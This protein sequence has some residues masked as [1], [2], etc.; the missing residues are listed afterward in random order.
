MQDGRAQVDIRKR[1][2]GVLARRAAAGEERLERLR[3]E[4]D[5]AVAFDAPGPASLERELL[6]SEHAELHSPQ[7]RRRARSGG[8]FVVNGESARVTRWRCRRG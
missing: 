3:R 2:L 1:V 5:H 7:P 4:L 6:R 8:P